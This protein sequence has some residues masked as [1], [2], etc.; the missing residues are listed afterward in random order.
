MKISIEQEYLVIPTLNHSKP[1][2]HNAMRRLL[3]F[4][5]TFLNAAAKH[6]G[7]TWGANVLTDPCFECSI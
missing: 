4:P 2:C 3:S 1:D 5:V 6:Q 7:S